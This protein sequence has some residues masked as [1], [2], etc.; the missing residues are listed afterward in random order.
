MTILTQLFHHQRVLV[1]T[2]SLHF[3]FKGCFRNLEGQGS[4]TES[5]VLS[6]HKAIQENIDTYFRKKERH[7]RS[8]SRYPLLLQE[9]KSIIMS[10]S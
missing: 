5:Q 7:D 9:A 2:H 8:F 1:A 3:L 4:L 10:D 6:W